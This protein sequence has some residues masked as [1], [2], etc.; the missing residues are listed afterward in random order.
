MFPGCSWSFRLASCDL[1][2]FAV[3]PVCKPCKYVLSFSTN[4]FSQWLNDV[5]SLRWN[6]YLQLNLSPF[7]AKH[8]QSKNSSHKIWRNILRHKRKEICLVCLWMC[9]S[10]KS[11]DKGLF[12]LFDLHYLGRGRSTTDKRLSECVKLKL[13][14]RIFY[15]F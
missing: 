4:E 10:N 13:W 15:Q 2:V 8:Y 5:H 11:P 1:D 14:I 6:K 3:K 9:H 12:A 7:T